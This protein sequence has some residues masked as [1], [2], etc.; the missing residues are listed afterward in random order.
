MACR[1][2]QNCGLLLPVYDRGDP[3]CWYIQTTTELRSTD[4][5]RFKL[6]R[7]MFAR[8]NCAASH[9]RA[10]VDRE[11]LGKMKCLLPSGAGE[12]RRLCLALGSHPRRPERRFSEVWRRARHKSTASV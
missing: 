3:I 6:F 8:M 4:P 5:Q 10:H 2:N 11:Q 7:E 12:R 1:F 9:F